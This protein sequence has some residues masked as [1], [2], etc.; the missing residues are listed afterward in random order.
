MSSPLRTTASPDPAATGMPSEPLPTRMPASTLS[1]M[2]ETACVIVTLPKP[3]ASRQL[4][5]PPGRVLAS[6]PVKV[7]HGA[8]RLHGLRSSPTPETQVRLACAEAA[9]L[10]SA[11]ARIAAEA[12][13][14]LLNDKVMIFPPIATGPAGIRYRH[15]RCR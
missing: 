11:P 1:Q 2:I 6:A 13:E 7:L 15:A 9:V 8:V 3:P 10:N 5:S 14:I 12:N 4:I